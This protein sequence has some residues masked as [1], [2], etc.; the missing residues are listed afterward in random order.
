MAET[1]SC[2]VTRVFPANEVM[3]H[4]LLGDQQLSPFLSWEEDSLGQCHRSGR[5]D[6]GSGAVLPCIF[7]SNGMENKRDSACVQ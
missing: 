2:E 7:G 1:V 6:W 5:G 3:F 4:M